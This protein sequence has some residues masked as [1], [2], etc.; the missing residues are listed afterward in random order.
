MPLNMDGRSPALPKAG[1]CNMAR[2]PAKMY[3]SAKG[4]SYTRREY[5]GGI[6]NSRITNFHMGNRVA[7]EKLEFPVELT[8]KVD[9]ACQIRH[10][11]LEAARIIV[12]ATIREAAGSQG[13]SLR[14]RVYPHQILR[15]NKQATGAGADRVSQGMRCAFGKNVGTA[16]RVTKNQKVITIQT[17]PAHF[18]AAKDALRKANCKLPTTS[19][20][21][22][23]RGHEH[24]KGLV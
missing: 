1:E 24:L 23:D 8:L 2:K 3:R 11:A 19:S 12:N 9:N 17:S 5:T 18:A 13:Y 20:I 21:I 10:T 7:G 16:A 22:V 6:P 15:E 4:L 14:V